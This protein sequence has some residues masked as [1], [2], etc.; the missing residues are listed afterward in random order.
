MTS[1]EVETEGV[2]LLDEAIRITGLAEC[3][4]LLADE[5]VAVKDFS[6]AQNLAWAYQCLASTANALAKR[7]SEHAP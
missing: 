7:L 2:T 6:N 1:D 3:L 5:T 4:Y